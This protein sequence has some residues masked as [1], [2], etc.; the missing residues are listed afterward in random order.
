[1]LFCTRAASC[2]NRVLVLCRFVNR[3]VFKR[4]D[5]EI[6]ILSLACKNMQR[7]QSK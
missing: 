5:R 6:T 1:M 4:L 7:M 3:V 2:C